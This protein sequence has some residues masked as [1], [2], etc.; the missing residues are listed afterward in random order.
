MSS[1]S[2]T[3]KPT[4]KERFW[5]EMRAFFIISAYLFV[6]FSVL[7]IYE[8]SLSGARS[9]TAVHLG[10]AAI[11]ALLLGKFLLI[12]KVMGAGNR[13]TFGRLFSDVAW[14]SLAYLGVL[15]VFKILEELIVGWVHGSS[16]GEVW[17]EYVNRG[18]L[19][20]LAPPLMMLMILVPMVFFVEFERAIGP[21]RMKALIHGESAD[22]ESS[23]SPL[24]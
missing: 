21:E 18:L 3:A 8:A 17:A 5:E 9:F 16:S 15:I 14:R 2:K 22:S 4:A 20:N 13:V 19:E 23:T 6:C 10:T 24:L 11:Q 12:G 1:E 7:R